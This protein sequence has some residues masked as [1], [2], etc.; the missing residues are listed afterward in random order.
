MLKNLA[1]PISR[2]KGGMGLYYSTEIRLH[3]RQTGNHGTEG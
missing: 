3:H 1:C 2:S